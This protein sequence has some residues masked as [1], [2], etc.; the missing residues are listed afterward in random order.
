ML[1]PATEAAE[2][3]AATD[4]LAGLR[5]LLDLCRLENEAVPAHDSPFRALRRGLAEAEVD[6]RGDRTARRRRI[7]GAIAA[8]AGAEP[9]TRTADVAARVAG[10]LISVTFTFSS[11]AAE[12]HLKFRFGSWAVDG[13][14]DHA[15]LVVTAAAYVALLVPRL[16]DGGMAAV[17]ERLKQIALVAAGEKVGQGTEASDWGKKLLRAASEP[18]VLTVL[19]HWSRLGLPE[20]RQL[21]S[22]MPTHPAVAALAVTDEDL[23]RYLLLCPLASQQRLTTDQRRVQLR[24]LIQRDGSQATGQLLLQACDAAL[25][26]L[27]T[28][29]A[30]ELGEQLNEDEARRLVLDLANLGGCAQG[31]AG[32]LLLRVVGRHPALTTLVDELAADADNAAIAAGALDSI[33][34]AHESRLVGVL[35]AHERWSVAA[36]LAG[37]L[38]ICRRLTPRQRGHEL[39]LLAAAWPDAPMAELALREVG[40][41][42]PD[43]VEVDAEELP[44]LAEGLSRQLHLATGPMTELQGAFATL[45]RGD[46]AQMTDVLLQHLERV[47]AQEREAPRSQPQLQALPEGLRLALLGLNGERAEYVTAQVGDWLGARLE[48]TQAGAWSVFSSRVSWR[49]SGR[50]PLRSPRCFNAW[51][52]GQLDSELWLSDCLPAASMNRSGATRCVGY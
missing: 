48:H 13:E 33:E 8:W 36:S 5:R 28:L 19:T 18:V 2:A 20:R 31:V 23:R 45:S 43:G 34:A 30:V 15:E 10:E 24:A 49:R 32:A 38:A 9:D 7:L 52:P 27:A 41:D 40:P 17:I 51:R 12:D 44:L 21:L 46:T 47:I 4:E 42:Q 50:G 25:N 3:L 11:R 29:L 22:A 16:D 35:R 39:L 6:W 14:P 1:H 26:R 37:H